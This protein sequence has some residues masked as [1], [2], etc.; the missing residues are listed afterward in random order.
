M[1][2]DWI[3]D[4]FFAAMKELDDSEAKQEEKEAEEDG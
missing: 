1:E 2:E 4:D 3:I